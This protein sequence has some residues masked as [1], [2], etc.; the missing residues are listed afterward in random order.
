M[1]RL[2]AAPLM[3]LLTLTAVSCDMW[4]SGQYCL[5]KGATS[6]PVGF[7]AD[8]IIL[9]QTRDFGQQTDRNGNPLIRLGSFGGSSLVSDDYDNR[10]TLTL[11]VCCHN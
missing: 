1:G 6:C 7:V 11:S 8:S 4:P 3:V 5:L 2:V 9:S 10:Y